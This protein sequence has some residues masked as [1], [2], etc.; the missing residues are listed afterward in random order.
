MCQLIEI[1]NAIPLTKEEWLFIVADLQNGVIR[2][3]S[4]KDCR[5]RLELVNHLRSTICA[6]W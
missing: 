5:K 4:C 1:E 3:T 2:P 6:G